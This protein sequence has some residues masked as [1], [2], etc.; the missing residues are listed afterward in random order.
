VQSQ[1]HRPIVSRGEQ[2]NTR[3]ERG[4][5]LDR[6]EALTAGGSTTLTWSAI[7]VTGCAASGSW[8]GAQNASGNTTVMPTTAGNYT[9][10]LTCTNA[11]GSVAASAKLT[12]MAA[13]PA[14]SGGGGGGLDA[15]ALLALAGLA[16]ARLLRRRRSTPS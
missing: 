14:S 16:C 7:N 10:T 4:R 2:Q 15:A 9:Y 1:P 12:V 6:L 13:P 3:D 11:Q 5:Q 8:N